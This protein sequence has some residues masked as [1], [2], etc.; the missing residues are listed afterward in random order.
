VRRVLLV[1]LVAACGHP[2]PAHVA[3][4]SPAPPPDAAL[5]PEYVESGGEF[6]NEDEAVAAMES[7]RDDYNR[8]YQACIDQCVDINTKRW[9]D[10]RPAEIDPKARGWCG[11]FACDNETACIAACEGYHFD[12]PAD[13]QAR[14]AAACDDDD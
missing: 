8:G 4:A 11:G 10:G 14:C 6:A 13:E 7:D 5:D 1:L 2:A 12:A 9:A 3:N